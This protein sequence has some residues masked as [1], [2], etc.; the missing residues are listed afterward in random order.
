[1]NRTFTLNY[2]LLAFG[3]PLC[4]IALMVLITQS[5]WFASNPGPL[6]IGITT[7]LA[8]IVPLTYFLLIRKTNIPKITVVPFITAGLIIATYS[9][10]ENHQSFLQI[11]K[12][13]MVPVIELGV[14]SFIGYNVYAIRKSFVA[15][16]D[17]SFDFF[18]AI[19]EATKDFLPPGVHHFFAMEIATFYYGFF[20]WRTRKISKGEFTY[21]K[22]SGTIAILAVIIMLVVV[23]TAVFH[24]LI[25]R[26]SSV[27]AWI[28][29]GRLLSDLNIPKT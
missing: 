25:Q 7:D 6:S 27:A 18:S 26:W 28:L 10:P 8:F 1:M 14:L 12:E 22:E 4:I 11:V 16:K 3:I 13:W 29:I 23:E 15:N 21:N 19:Q 24:L 17:T 2:K 9:I 5:V 20:N